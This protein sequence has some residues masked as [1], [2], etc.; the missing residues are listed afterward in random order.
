MSKFEAPLTGSE[1]LPPSKIGL[2]FWL[3]VS[4]QDV[5][6]CKLEK[7]KKTYKKVAKSFSQDLALAQRVITIGFLRS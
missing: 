6:P 7:K 2:F 3:F 1:G 5:E 4:S